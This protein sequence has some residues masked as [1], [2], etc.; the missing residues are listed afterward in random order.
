MAKFKKPQDYDL[1]PET[2]Q[3]ILAEE[4]TAETEKKDIFQ[5]WDEHCTDMTA[6]L[7]D[8]RGP[9][10]DTLIDETILSI[11]KTRTLTERVKVKLEQ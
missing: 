3:E 8:L 6:S 2:T 11:A 7:N 4:M 1:V 5:L 10:S 9:V